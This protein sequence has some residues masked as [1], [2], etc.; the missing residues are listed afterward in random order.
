MKITEID[1]VQVARDESKF[2][3]GWDI[4]IDHRSFVCSMGPR[5]AV[6]SHAWDALAAATD[7]EED[8]LAN[9]PRKKMPTFVKLATSDVGSDGDR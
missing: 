2:R 4:S 1:T 7:H 6:D 3:Y 5:P 8:S 9:V